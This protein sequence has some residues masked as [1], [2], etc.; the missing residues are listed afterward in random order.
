MAELEEL[1][2]KNWVA[3][4]MLAW[5]LGSFG[6]HRFYT[7]KT[8]TAWAMAIMTVT[9]CLSPISIIWSLID[10]LMIALGNWKHEDGSELYERIAGLGYLYIV[11]LVLG[12]ISA[13]FQI[14]TMMMM[15]GVAAGG[16][17]S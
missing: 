3:T 13:L 6:A 12:V 5:T 10:A 9:I 1:K 2:G 15:L 4:M 8:G 7:G 11:L 14:G 17:G 16:A